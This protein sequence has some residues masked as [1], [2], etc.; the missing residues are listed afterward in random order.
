MAYD[1]D[2]ELL[3]MLDK[4]NDPN[5]CFHDEDDIDIDI[6]NIGDIDN[7]D[8]DDPDI[9][10][11]LAL[12]FKALEL[13]TT[14]N[15]TTAH[16]T[17]DEYKQHAKT[18]MLAGNKDEALRLMKMAKEQSQIEQGI[19]NPASLIRS[20]SDSNS[21]RSKQSNQK[22]SSSPSILPAKSVKPTASIQKV[23]N[24]TINSTVVSSPSPNN[25]KNMKISTPVTPSLEMSWSLLI[26]ALEEAIDICKTEA[27]DLGKQGRKTDAIPFMAKL[28]EYQ[29]ELDTAKSRLIIPQARPVLF[30]W[31]NET[32]QKTNENVDLGDDQI[33]LVIDSAVDMGLLLQTYEG[34]VVMCEYNLAIPKDSPKTGKVE[35]KV[36]AGV[37]SFQFKSLFEVTLKRGSQ[38]LLGSFSRRSAT[39]TLSLQ[40]K[41]FFSS[42]IIPLGIATLPLNVL[43]TKCECGGRLHLYNEAEGRNRSALPGALEV[44][45]KL[46]RP[47]DKPDVIVTTRSILILD[48][49]SSVDVISPAL[50]K[51]VDSPV[52]PP[53][54]QITRIQREK[55][56]ETTKPKMDFSSLTDEEKD[57][58][59][60]PLI[61]M[62]NK[63][64]EKEIEEETSKL[65]T[66]MS[67][68]DRSNS[69]IRLDSLNMQM[70][71]LISAV[72]DGSLSVPVYKQILQRQIERDKKLALYFTSL[73]CHDDN[74][75][76]E[77]KDVAIKLLKRSKLIAEEL[78]EIESMKDDDI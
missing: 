23:A 78:Q 69:E 29:K 24:N 55:S 50:V 52:N 16:M 61:M 20:N 38:S 73:P 59:F 5:Y 63:A 44:Y 14:S 68:D 26:S 10:K 27:L 62:S 57:G 56:A 15:I 45:L 41:G 40:K 12:E 13:E 9:D 54:L 76:V 70:G 60:S 74:E 3:T 49:W 47:I 18:A 58:P 31:Q 11:Q 1:N 77:N 34:C 71:R 28:K 67:E 46:R 6:D 17:S 53:P 37:V 48:D 8:D 33:Q 66:S 42:T 2:H 72:Q 19:N 7:N 64:L 75:A 32:I 39:F 51:T 36:K 21:P 25:E 43:L 22:S 35:G 65:A 4:L 30:R